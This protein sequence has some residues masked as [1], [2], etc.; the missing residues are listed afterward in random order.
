MSVAFDSRLPG[1]PEAAWQEAAPWR[2]AAE[3]DLDHDRVIV[4]A[5]HPDDETLGAAG[6]LRHA[7]RRGADV[8]LLVVTDGDAAF[9]GAE[10]AE[11]GRRRR[12]EL[13][14]A[15]HLLGPG[16][17]VTFLGVPDG[18]IREARAHVADAVAAAVSRTTAG[19]TL[20][21][22]PWWGD[23]HRDHRVLG[24]IARTMA[25][26]G[27]TVRG[28]PIWLWHWGTPTEVDT[29]AWS[30]VPLDDDDRRAKRRAIAAH[31]SQTTATRAD[32]PPMLH[33]ETLR[34]FDRDV[35]VFIAPTSDE[36]ASA[37]TP[38]EFDAFHARHD[39]PWGL[40][41]R[42]Y[43]E[44]KRALLLAALPRRSFARVLE[45]GCAG[46]AT[47]RALAPRASTVVAVDASAVAL[48]RA[49]ARGVPE[50]T[51]YERR[52]LPEDWPTGAFD[53]FVLSELGYYWTPDRLAAAFD[54][55]DGTATD[56]AVLVLCHWRGAISDA[57]ST[58]DDVHRAAAARP[59]WRMLARHIEEDFL[60]D[61]LVRADVPS[62][63]RAE[64]LR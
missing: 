34:H 27:V 42:W 37:P 46:G 54:R 28:Y 59:G 7:L 33:A 56:D 50:G 53:L 20:L 11:V 48:E 17:P 6:T 49:R 9:E 58:G 52:E 25:G 22:A 51:V 24:E 45:L 55:I 18:G 36:A 15:V 13:L 44:R 5:A 39:D 4:L 63:A 26:A 62:V 38:G 35:E 61:V 10:R 29:A 31:R 57:P 1:T 30:V 32:E 14:D 8:S 43:E 23:G 12:G 2:G 19:R 21:L 16:I 41:S 60:L 40:E 3:L 64:G 47:T